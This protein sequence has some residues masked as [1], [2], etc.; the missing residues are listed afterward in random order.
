MKNRHFKIKNLSPDYSGDIKLNL[1]KVKEEN[2]NTD[3]DQME[4][5]DLIS[6][7]DLGVDCLE[8]EV[9]VRVL[10]GKKIQLEIKSRQIISKILNG[11]AGEFE[12]LF[13][14]IFDDYLGLFSSIADGQGG[15]FGLVH[16]ETGDWVYETSEFSPSNLL[17]L[18]HLNTFLAFSDIRTYAWT[19]T[20]ILLLKMG[21]DG[22]FK[23]GEL[24]LK[25]GNWQN[26]MRESTGNDLPLAETETK[27]SPFLTRIPEDEERR[28][29]LSKQGDVA[30]ITHIPA[31]ILSGF[32]E[33]L[34]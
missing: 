11:Y 15:G 34:A 17:W 4:Y 2:P 1:S 19:S 29:Q 7:L 20:N 27:T 18:P 13:A 25:S 26:K 14:K 28:L 8:D 22:K 5:C 16:I 24:N 12:G 9:W 31:V 32:H 23:A 10:D 30:Y 6:E 33:A 3:I 21:E